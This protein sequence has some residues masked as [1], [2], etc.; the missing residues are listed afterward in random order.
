MFVTVGSTRFDKLISRIFHPESAKQLVDLGFANLILQVG[1][2]EV[3]SDHVEKLK[4]S[5]E[6]EIDIYD[7]KSSILDDIQ[8]SDVVVGHAGAGT[9][10]E[11]LRQNK[12]LLIVVNDELMD[13]HQSE[14]ADQLA[15]ENYVVQTT[16][17]KF[18]EGLAVI[19]DGETKLDRFPPKNPAKFEEI[20]EE[21][22]RRVSS[23]L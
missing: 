14:L 1:K 4:K 15:N 8:K 13:N 17:D 19:C 22:L 3:D 6:L 21:A 7:Y 20:F 2:S 18:N 11:V 23:R 10:L 5:F 9:C 12:R 16:V